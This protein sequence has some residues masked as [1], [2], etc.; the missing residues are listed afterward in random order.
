MGHFD[1]LTKQDIEFGQR[2][3]DV[4]GSGFFERAGVESARGYTNRTRFC[5]TGR[6]HVIG[7]IANHD[8]AARFDTKYR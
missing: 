6:F 7:G 2:S 1:G 8:A 4:M 3:D 5:I